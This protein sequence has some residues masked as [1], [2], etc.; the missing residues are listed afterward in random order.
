MLVRCDVLGCNHEG[1]AT[2]QQLNTAG[3]HSVGSHDGQR[4]IDTVYETSLLYAACCPS[5]SVQGHWKKMEL[6]SAPVERY[7][8]PEDFH[9]RLVQCNHCTGTGVNKP[10]GLHTEPCKN[11]GGTGK[12]QA[13]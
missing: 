5:C 11:C 6:P 7:V 9:P 10:T 12:V 4:R 13:G 3:W 2:I 8:T 1:I